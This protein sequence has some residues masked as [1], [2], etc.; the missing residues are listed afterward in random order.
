LQRFKTL[1]KWAVAVLVTL[2][3][4][5][6]LTAVV[7]GATTVTATLSPDI[8]VRFDWK[9]QVLWDGNGAPIY[10]ILYEGS[11]YLPVRAVSNMAGLVVNWVDSTRTVELSTDAVQEAADTT[12]SAIMWLVPLVGE[13]EVILA[14]DIAVKF[15]G[16]I[17][18]L[19]DVNGNIIYPLLYNGSTYLPVRAISELVGL[20]VDWD[21]ATR[22]VELRTTPEP[23]VT[24]VPTQGVFPPTPLNV[25]NLRAS[26]YI[27]N[28][29]VITTSGPHIFYEFEYDTGTWTRVEDLFYL[30]LQAYDY[31]AIFRVSETVFNSI[32]NFVVVELWRQYE[33]VYALRWIYEDEQIVLTEGTEDSMNYIRPLNPNKLERCVYKLPGTVLA[34]LSLPGR[35]SSFYVDAQG[36]RGVF[37]TQRYMEN[38]S[39]G[40]LVDVA[41]VES[42]DLNDVYT[43]SSENWFENV[44]EGSSCRFCE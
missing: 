8:T 7:F 43:V 5:T 16:D 33:D 30:Y 28:A 39:V 41:L 2:V 35:P 13:I 10:P 27:V 32:G 3:S 12:P 26:S 4:M 24:F 15:N 36:F 14:A 40:D 11:T 17:Q 42:W 29:A 21:A 25:G 37:S 34:V 31:T 6:V 22:T 44:C 9:T 18:T 20:Y 38:I 1:T 19:R 23:R